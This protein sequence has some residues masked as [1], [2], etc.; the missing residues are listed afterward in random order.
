MRVAAS[1]RGVIAAATVAAAMQISA[2]GA[3]VLYSNFGPSDS[4]DDF[5]GWLVGSFFSGPQV[6]QGFQFT[7]PTGHNYR[8]ASV[9]AALSL[10][11]GDND[12]D[13]SLWSDVGGLP[14]AMLESFHFSGAMSSFFDFPPPPRPL[15]T[16][17]SLLK[18]LL[19]GGTPYWVVVDAAPGG[20][21]NW[22]LNTTGSVLPTATSQ[23]G[24]ATFDLVPADLGVD[25]AGTFRVTGTV[26]EPASAL[27]LGMGLLAFVRR[28]KPI[29]A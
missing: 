25:T 11:D 17:A 6:A 9:T 15:L 19:S 26:P 3:A 2:A 20:T 12:V 1:F 10:F 7:V 13:I 27:L 14:G 28:R 24:M 4:Y 23:D 8:F 21:A 29:A 16:G 18:P 22:H 5:S